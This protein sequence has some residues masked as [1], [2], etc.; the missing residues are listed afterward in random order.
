MASTAPV[1]KVFQSTR[2]AR[3]ATWLRGYFL[4]FFPCFNPRAPRGARLMT[5]VTKPGEIM[6]SIHAPRAGRDRPR[7]PSATPNRRF[8]PRAPRGA[9]H[10]PVDAAAD[11]T[12]F[13][14]RAPRGA[15]HDDGQSVLMPDE[16]QSTRPA[17]GATAVTNPGLKAVVE[18]QSTRP[19]RGATG[20]QH[21][22]PADNHVSIHA[23]RA[24]RDRRRLGEHPPSRVSIHAPR[25]GRDRNP[26]VNQALVRRF[27]PR[28]P[29][30]A[31]PTG[32]S[33]PPAGRGFNPRAPRGA[34]R[35]RLRSHTLTPRVSIH[36]PRAGRDGAGLS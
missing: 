25:A 3:G 2:P 10:V 9:R 16:F 4:P 30:G 28:A 7:P 8:N 11:C 19:A 34:R 1:S 17:R 20:R 35:P 21:R 22:P 14:P 36:A 5:P 31:R 18:F 12:S 24:G 26:V 32:A 13:N 15:R 33:S 29:R 23:P 27:N 6:V